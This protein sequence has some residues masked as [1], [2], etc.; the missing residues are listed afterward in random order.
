V[1]AAL[2][3]HY[4]DSLHP[5]VLAL[6]KMNSPEPA[7]YSWPQ[8]VFEEGNTRHLL[9]YSGSGAGFYLAID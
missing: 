8:W 7:G 2:D 1:I 6:G 9:R 3:V 4:D 5:Q